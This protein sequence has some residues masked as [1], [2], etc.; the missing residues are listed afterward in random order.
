MGPKDD[1]KQLLERCKNHLIGAMR[2]LPDCQP[3]SR[4]AGAKEIEKAAGFELHLERQDNWL[5]WSL[6]QRMG[7]DGMIEIVPSGRARYRL[8]S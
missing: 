8:R 5:K 1:G 2:S 6:L 4:G 7:R 3:Y